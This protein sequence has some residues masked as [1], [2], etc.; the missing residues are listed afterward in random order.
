MLK[1]LGKSALC[2]AGLVAASWLVQQLYDWMHS[3]VNSVL[4]LLIWITI[5]QYIFGLLLGLAYAYILFLIFKKDKRCWVIIMLN[6]VFLILQLFYLF[7]LHANNGILHAYD[8]VVLLSMHIACECGLPVIFLALMFNS[9]KSERGPKKKS[10]NKTLNALVLIAKSAICFFGLAAISY[11]FTIMHNS[12]LSVLGIIGLFL[13]NLF[14]VLPIVAVVYA[15]SLYQFFRNEGYRRLI[16]ILN[17]VFLII[18]CVLFTAWNQMDDISIILI[19]IIL[20]NTGILTIVLAFIF[21]SV[22]KYYASAPTEQP[23]QPI[24]ETDNHA[25]LTM[26]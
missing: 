10:P 3:S 18:L 21:R 13:D 1:I 22:D 5:T 4:L 2:F 23:L 17:A 9:L 11:G 16:L 14:F 20:G 19:A 26:Q 24:P 6:G 12:L 15:Y 7:I 25:D 8:D